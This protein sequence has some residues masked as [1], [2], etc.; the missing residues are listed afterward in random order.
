MSAYYGEKAVSRNSLVADNCIVEGE[1]ENC[2]LFSG[3]RVG[4]GAQLKNCIIFQDT[5]VGDRCRMNHVISDKNCSF[6]PDTVLCGAEKMPVV[7]GKSK[8]I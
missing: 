3:V 7:V 1:I 6:A 8:R 2:I 4:E 5:V